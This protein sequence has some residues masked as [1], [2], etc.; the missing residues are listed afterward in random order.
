MLPDIFLMTQSECTFQARK[1]KQSDFEERNDSL[2]TAPQKRGGEDC[3]GQE[4]VSKISSLK[5]F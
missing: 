3:S 2:K 4:P 1:I 5:P